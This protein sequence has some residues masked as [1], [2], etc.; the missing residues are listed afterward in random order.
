MLTAISKNLFIREVLEY[1]ARCGAAL[2]VVAVG[3]F[4]D[5]KIEGFWKKQ[6]SNLLTNQLI[7]EAFLFKRDVNGA[8]SIR[9]CSLALQA[10]G[11]AG[12]IAVKDLRGSLPEPFLSLYFIEQSVAGFLQT[13]F[14]KVAK[15][16][17]SE[18]LRTLI[19]VTGLEVLFGIVLQEGLLRQLP[20]YVFTATRF[21]PPE[22]VDSL[23]FRIGRVILSSGIFGLAF[24]KGTSFGVIGRSTIKKFLSWGVG[25]GY[26]T[27][28]F[29]FAP[30][31]IQLLAG[32]LKKY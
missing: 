19:Q 30:A 22:I 6:T 1:G 14:K 26:L 4:V 20:K 21:C 12:K 9:L 23:P 27:E 8:N 13:P 29:G 18:T 3:S 32:M 10:A 25:P 24:S 5:K 2:G 11:A 17:P 7:L 28:V 31:A 16:M 15:V